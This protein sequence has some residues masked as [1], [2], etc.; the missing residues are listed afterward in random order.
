MCNDCQKNQFKFRGETERERNNK[1]M[2]KQKKV[3]WKSRKG[4]E[5]RG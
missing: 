4:G 3:G 2:K 5:T 1:I